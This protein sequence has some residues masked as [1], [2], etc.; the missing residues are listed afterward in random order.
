PYNDFTHDK[1]LDLVALVSFVVTAFVATD[2]LVRAQTQAAEAERRAVEIASLARL[3]SET[4]SSGRA[5][6]ALARIAEVIKS[7]LKVA[8]CSIPAWDPE[9]GFTAS[10]RVPV[11]AA[12]SDEALLRRA[13]EGPKPLWVRA[14]GEVID[15]SSPDGRGPSAGDAVQRIIMPLS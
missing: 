15:S 1:P 8:A 6:D 12:A 9:R 3:G 13:I 10:P 5:E 11:P 2:L 14:S 7:T 4:L